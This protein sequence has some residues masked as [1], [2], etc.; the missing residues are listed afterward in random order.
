MKEEFY[1]LIYRLKINI[2]IFNIEKIIFGNPY[3]TK[4]QHFFPYKGI[5]DKNINLYVN[6]ANQ[7][8]I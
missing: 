6:D 1:N 4:N 5:V 3:D 8:Q 7:N 2:S